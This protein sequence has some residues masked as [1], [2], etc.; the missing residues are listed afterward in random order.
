MP[1]LAGLQVS[2]TRLHLHLTVL[3]TSYIVKGQQIF[4][5]IV[6]YT[7][8]YAAINTLGLYLILAGKE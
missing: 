7:L 2:T 1:T 3:L 6:L 5:F 4:F 8:L